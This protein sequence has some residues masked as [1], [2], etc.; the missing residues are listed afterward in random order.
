MSLELIQKIAFPTFLI[1]LGVLMVFKPESAGKQI[2]ELCLI[3]PMVHKTVV[4]QPGPRNKFIVVMGAV[5]VII[6]L[7]LG[8]V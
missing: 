8:F 5:F 2:K 6:G 1:I 4:K 3:N 7:F